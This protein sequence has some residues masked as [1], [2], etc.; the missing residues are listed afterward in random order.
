[1]SSKTRFAKGH[2]GLIFFAIACLAGMAE[3]TAV[4][5][6]GLELRGGGATFPAPLYQRW[7][8]DFAQQHPNLQI[9]YAAVGSGEGIAA[10]PRRRTGFCSQRCRPQR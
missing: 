10:V 7:I 8:A 4:Q 9:G 3:G 6:G 5:A 2:R 1:M